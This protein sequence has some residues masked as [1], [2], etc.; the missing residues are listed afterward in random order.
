[1]SEKENVKEKIK[2]LDFKAGAAMHDRILGDVLKAH[3]KSKNVKSAEIQLSVWRIIMKSRITKVAAAAVII[4]AVIS[5]LNIIGGPDMASVAWADV[6]KNIE[7]IQT[8]IARTKT[9]TEGLS[10]VI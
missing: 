1:M 4:I 9:R 3:D 10:Y 5:G 6:V 2:R 8:S 7:Q